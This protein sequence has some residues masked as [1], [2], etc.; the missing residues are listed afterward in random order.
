LVDYFGNLLDIQNQ[1]V[2]T[3]D[4]IPDSLF[5]AQ[6]LCSMPISLQVT[7]KFIHQKLKMTPDE[8][9]GYIIKISTALHNM[10][11]ITDVEALATEAHDMKDKKWYC[12]CKDNSHRTSYCTSNNHKEEK[13]GK[14]R[15][16]K[17]KYDSDNHV[18]HFHCGGEGHTK[19]VCDRKKKGE[20]AWGKKFKAKKNGSNDDDNLYMEIDGL[21]L[22]LW[23]QKY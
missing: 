21:D 2:G 16:N 6:I 9:M 20:A 18:V 14:I 3:P 15:T 11:P 1:L 12:N 23:S 5:K 19:D 13:D 7:I 8:V 4:Q 22:L 10:K 17:C